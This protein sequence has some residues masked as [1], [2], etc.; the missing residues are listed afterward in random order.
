MLPIGLVNNGCT[1][2]PEMGTKGDVHCRVFVT[3]AIITQ[4]SFPLS[5]IFQRESQFL[6]SATL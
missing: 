1:V 5:A 2:T 3:R 6:I 4:V